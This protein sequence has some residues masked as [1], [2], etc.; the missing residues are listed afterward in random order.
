MQTLECR[1]ADEIFA[2]STATDAGRFELEHADAHVMA[3]DDHE[4]P[5]AECSLWWSEGPSLAHGRIGVIGHYRAAKDSAAQMLLATAC[6][7]LRSAGCTCAVGPMDGNTWRS[8]RFVTEAGT[9]PTFFLEPQNPP[10]W[11]Q[12]FVLAGFSPLAN[13]LSALN[14]DLFQPDPR[15]R[16]A[17]TRL[18]ALGVVLRSSRPGEAAD[19]LRRIYGVACVA[20]RNNFLYTELPQDDFLRQ[21]EKLLPVLRP[22]L[23][24]LAEQ[25]TE[26]VGFV[27]AV[28]DVLRQVPGTPIDTFIL[29]TVAILPRRELRGLGTLLV[30]RVQEIG[31]ELGFRRCIGALM[32]E[33]NTLVRNISA[34]YGKPIRRYTLFAKDLAA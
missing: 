23:L 2:I 1:K 8:Y 3:L 34:T 22:E 18:R 12:H 9:E 4:G 11:P 17:E 13:Y 14:A 31:R 26:V 24:M 21:Y 30:G 33:R 16:K 20:F 32:H 28:P 15:L 25:Q 19:C 29:K 6:D 7:R 10:E 5:L 27:F